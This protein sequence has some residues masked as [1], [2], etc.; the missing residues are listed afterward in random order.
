MMPVAQEAAK[1]RAHARSY[2]APPGPPDDPWGP[3]IEEASRK[4]DVP[5]TWV[6]AVIG[7]ESGGQ[8]FSRNGTLITSGAGAMGLMQLM[9]PTYDDLRAQYGLGDDPFEPHDNIMAGTAYIRQMYDI[10]GAPGFLAAYNTGPG[11]LDD[12]L[13]KNRP[14][15]RET[16]QYVAIIGPQ[17]AGI[18][19]NSRSQ[20]DLMIAA[21]SGSDVQYASAQT[22]DETKSVRLAWTRRRDLQQPNDQPM[23]VAEAPATTGGAAPSYI[24][25]WRSMKAQSPAQAAVATPVAL[26]ANSPSSVSAAWASRGIVSRP[27]ASVASAPVR[28]WTLAPTDQ[29]HPAAIASGD[30]SGPDTAVAPVRLASAEM[31]A[32][33]DSTDTQAAAPAAR[34]PHFQLIRRAMAEPAPLLRDA[35]RGP[36]N[37]SVQVGAFNTQAQASQAAGAARSRAPSLSGAQ[38]EIA[39]VKQGRNGRVYRARLTGLS[40]NDAMAACQKLSRGSG[41]CMVVSPDAR[42]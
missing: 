11:R 20:A 10:Y 4:F 13:T 32:Q 23:Q 25:D 21:H 35:G 8:Q 31:P 1:Y 24:K 39:G 30:S 19:P 34:K 16:R 38:A 18:W 17:I 26:A 42:S 6:R 7:R 36:R 12:F 15:P 28:N 22:Q 2:Y 37:W 41:A 3:Y 14:L 9:A 5:D 33:D 27:A 29:Q 40:R